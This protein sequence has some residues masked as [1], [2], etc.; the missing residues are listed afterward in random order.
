MTTTPQAQPATEKA[1]NSNRILMLAVFSVFL[2]PVLI[3]YSAHFFGWYKDFGT[4]NRGLLVTPPIESAA[5]DIKDKDGNPFD[6][7]NYPKTWF[8]VYVPPTDCQAAC[9]NSLYLMRQTNKAMGPERNR[10][11]RILLN[12]QNNGHDFDG[13]VTEN[14]PKMLSFYGDKN[15]INQSLQNALDQEPSAVEAGR[16][17]I[18][19]PLGFIMLSYP[20]IADEKESILKGKD[21]VKDL[22]RL[23]KVS[24][25][26]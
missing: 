7:T 26:G 10:V 21:L 17:Y 8:L 20:A 13:F 2:L 23:L 1:N 14:F 24:K 4:N 3:A 11:K 6:S 9:K 5:L 19:D 22:K 16:I 15:V 12:W 18:M 25:I